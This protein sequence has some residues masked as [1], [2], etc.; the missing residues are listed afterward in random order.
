MTFLKKLACA[1]AVALAAGS[2]HA[3]S[4]MNDWTFNP[5]GGGQAAGKHVNEYLDVNG[6][7]FIQIKATGGN[8]FNFT[9]HGAFNI[10]QA[11]GKGGL[12]PLNYAG[13]N[14]SATLSAWGTGTFSGAFT[15]TGGS[16]KMY[17]NPTNNEYSTRAGMYGANRGN[18]IGEFTVLAGG[19]GLVDASG[20]PTGNGQ[21]SI[22]AQ[23]AAGGL[24]AGYFFAD[25]G[26]DMSTV[27]N[28]AFA[29]TNA[30]TV[31]HP[32]TEMV[33]EIACEFALYTGPGCGKKPKVGTY[34][35][36][37]GS[38]FFVSNNG[39]FKFAD[40]PEPGSVAL[41]G[42]ALLGFGAVRRRMK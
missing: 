9:E 10:V 12:F 20:N 30:N 11:D 25:N 3:E 36:V 18:L 42:I 17:Q 39:Q 2:V 41:F 1:A 7:A 4:V 31:G 13:G 24:K 40:I 15:F 28:T 23:A 5:I 21:V 37:A 6:N 32:T 16:I 29:F 35:N 8:S 22:R 14:I 26:V 33:K 27:K 38:H 19:G 34:A